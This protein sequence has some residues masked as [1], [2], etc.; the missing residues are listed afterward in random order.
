[1]KNRIREIRNE[2]GLTL[3]ELSDLLYISVSA[4][5]KIER[6]ERKLTIEMAHEIALVFEITL[7]DLVDK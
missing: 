5:S 3:K 2:N 1:M 7:N 4:L 6:G